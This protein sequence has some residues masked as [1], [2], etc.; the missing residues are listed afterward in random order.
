MKLTSVE[1]H[2]A[3]SSDVAVLS[4]RDPG[5]QNPFNVKGIAGLDAEEIVSRYYG[6]SGSSAMYNL[7]LEK[8]NPVILI[9]LNPRF[10]QNETYSDLRDRIYKLIAS[11][12]TGM[13]QMQFKNGN[14]VV[15][16][17]SGFV[18]KVEAP[19]FEKI[20]Q[21]QITLECRDPLLRALTP[22]VI[23]V[24]SLDPANT[25]LS[26]ILSTAPHGFS[27]QLAFT[28]G[29]EG[30][31]IADPDNPTWSFNV[32]PVGGFLNGDVLHFSSEYNDKELYVV[33]GGVTTHL[34]DKIAPNSVWPLIFPGDNHFVLSNPTN[35][36]W[37]SIEHYPTYWGV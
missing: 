24:S 30:L 5:Q 10:E 20:Q 27:F 3:G 34:A 23:D 37:V 15:A 9:G 21:V 6:G 4:F 25:I 28:G 36:D 1:L 17:V 2:P 11:S 26:D 33:R 16:A 7:S 22:T 19:Q 32:T 8:R 29:V 12:R 31:T 18:Q 35:L 13:L 14:T